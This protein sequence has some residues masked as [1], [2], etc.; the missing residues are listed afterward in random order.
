MA[1][2]TYINP[3][4]LHSNPA[5]SQVVRVPAGADLVYVGGQNGVDASGRVVGPDL[6]AQVRQSLVNLRACLAAAGAEPSDV[7][8]WTLLIKEGVSLQEGFAA[9]GAE[10]GYLPNPPAITAAFVSNLAVEGA[11]V[12]IEAVAAVVAN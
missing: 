6:A 2:A 5:F 9:F 8:K 3:E 10:W 4:S 11:L 7:V 1:I 12:E